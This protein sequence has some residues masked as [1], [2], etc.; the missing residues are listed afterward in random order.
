MR[1]LSAMLGIIGLAC[2]NSASAQN[3]RLGIG[4]SATHDLIRGW[5]IDVRF[6]G[7]G[8]PPGRGSVIE[9]GKIFAEQCAACHGEKAQKPTKSFD[10]LAGGRGTL[11][12]SKPI[13]TVGSYWPYAPTIFDYVNR[14]MPFPAPQTLTANEVYA[15]VAY[16]LYV[17][18]IVPR[19]AVM[20]A[21]TLAKV[22]MPNADGFI[23]DA[24]PD[25]ADSKCANDCN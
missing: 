6:D 9:G 22:K 10:R 5:D 1:T 11:A 3:P 20:D 13:Q 7:V 24:R 21:H 8:L 12:T 17:N 18:D 4:T 25:T 23:R 16:L 15:V 2:V 19:D 14:A